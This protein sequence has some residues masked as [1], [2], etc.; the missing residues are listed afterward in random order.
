M[1]NNA[2]FVNYVIR[3]VIYLFMTIKLFI[4]IIFCHAI[5]N[6][7]DIIQII[8]FQNIAAEFHA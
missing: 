3:K 2:I 4:N 5:I 6:K 8:H 1:K 7:P